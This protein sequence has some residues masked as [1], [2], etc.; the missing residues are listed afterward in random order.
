MQNPPYLPTEII[1]ARELKTLRELQLEI[2]ALQKRRH[3]FYPAQWFGIA[4][5][6]RAE[7]R[8]NPTPGGADAL[9]EM[10]A[11]DP[12][13]AVN[14]RCFEKV[15]DDI[16]HGA[17]HIFKERGLALLSLVLARA[18]N[19]SAVALQRT[20]AL[21][22][23]MASHAADLYAGP[24]PKT[25][26]VVALEEMGAL[27][28]RLRAQVSAPAGVGAFPVHIGEIL[29]K[30]GVELEMT[31]SEFA[32]PPSA[33][34][35]TKAADARESAFSQLTDKELAEVSHQYGVVID[36]ANFDRAT[37][38]ETILAIAPQ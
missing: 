6:V 20:E 35:P 3:A 8:R 31:L 2:D 18:A 22:E 30:V 23:Q 14:H 13:H 34:P 11:L 12:E 15:R 16:T 37:A 38:I 36:A 9:L 10:L 24:L 28:E 33:L 25:K 21:D 26:Q 7:F 1:T 5:A 32:A 27:I 4:D 29:E 19:L 17:C